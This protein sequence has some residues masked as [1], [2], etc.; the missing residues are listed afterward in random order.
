[1]PA[2]LALGVVLLVA[3]VLGTSCG[4]RRPNSE[5][6]LPQDIQSLAVPVF[7]NDTLEPDLGRVM[8]DALLREIEK[9][10]RI[11]LTSVD[12]A[13]AVVRGRVLAYRERPVAFGAGGFAR[14][15]SA[16]VTVD[17]EVRRN[18]AVIVA[19]RGLVEDEEYNTT[20]DPLDTEILRRHA[21]AAIAENLMER[22]HRLLLE[23]F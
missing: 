21:Q 7:D 12:Q 5:T 11:R 14:A 20:S 10:H 18:G 13:D 1:M 16:Q 4:Y 3:V 9:G 23:A 8:T 2:S 22:V 19:H 6:A 17:I 15:Y